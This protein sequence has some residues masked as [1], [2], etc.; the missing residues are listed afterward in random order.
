MVL[1]FKEVDLYLLIVRASRG[2]ENPA[3]DCEPEELAGKLLPSKTDE[4]AEDERS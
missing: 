4:T 3:A 1:R 2:C